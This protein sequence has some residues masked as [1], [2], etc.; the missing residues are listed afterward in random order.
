MKERPIRA[1]F[2]VVLTLCLGTAF[3]VNAK[4]S[5]AQPEQGLRLRLVGTVVTDEP[6]TRFAIIEVQ[7]TGRQG[8]FHEGDRWGDILIKRIHPGYVIIDAGKGD[9][10]LYL[11]SGGDAGRR[12]SPGET[13]RLERKERARTGATMRGERR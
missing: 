12:A 11:G 6:S 10:V 8:A 1:L 3:L 4:A 9:I 13:V 2:G 5:G 7:S